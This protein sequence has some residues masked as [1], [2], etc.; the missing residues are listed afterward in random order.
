MKTIEKNYKPETKFLERFVVM[1]PRNSMTAIEENYITNKE[2]PFTKNWGCCS[3]KNHKFDRIKNATTNKDSKFIDPIL[4]INKSSTI[5]K[6][7][8]RYRLNK[9]QRIPLLLSI[10]TKGNLDELNLDLGYGF[11]FAQKFSD[12]KRPAFFKKDAIIQFEYGSGYH[13][14]MDDPS[15]SA[16]LYFC[17]T[18]T[19]KNYLKKIS[20]Q[21][22]L[23]VRELHFLKENSKSIKRKK[24]QKN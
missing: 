15:D 24:N 14:V 23:T 12:F 1:N 7:L 11:N 9:G 16:N 5:S 22:I 19:W 13:Q 4:L 17:P 6:S 3:G 10:E 18:E 2:F 8:M 20:N 21:K